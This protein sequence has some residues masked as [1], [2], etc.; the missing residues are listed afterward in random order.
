MRWL[1]N[2][3]L[4]GVSLLNEGVYTGDL[5][6]LEA[7]ISALRQLELD[8]RHIERQRLDFGHPPDSAQVDAAGLPADADPVVT[9]ER[10]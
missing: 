1:A 6:L 5:V 3:A 10:L 9:L 4:F 7:E 2:A 8:K